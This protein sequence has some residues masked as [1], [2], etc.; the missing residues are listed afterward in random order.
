MFYDLSVEKSLLALGLSLILNH[1][2]R[3]GSTLVEVVNLCCKELGV[4]ILMAKFGNDI[5]DLLR[6]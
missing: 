3:Y 2:L 1:A 6:T 4:K 5:L